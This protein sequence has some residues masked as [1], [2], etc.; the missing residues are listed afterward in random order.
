L[1]ELDKTQ[2]ILERKT[3][4]IKIDEEKKSAKIKHG[5]KHK[6]QTLYKGKPSLL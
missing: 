1:E 4:G 5:F 2:V 3:H 6:Q